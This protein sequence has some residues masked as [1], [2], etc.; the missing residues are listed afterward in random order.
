V[1]LQQAE[2]RMVRWLCG[3][4]LQDKVQSKGLRDRLG[5][6]DIISVLPQ[7]RLRWYRHVLQK[8]DNDWVK[9]IRMYEVVGARPI[10]RP[11]KTWREIVEK[12]CQAHKLNT[13]IAMDRNRW[14]K[15]M[16]DG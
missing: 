1:A 6:N 4:K 2:M 3:I 11:K 7:D 13:E 8:E 12:G 10:G 15:Q 9:K 14:R 5:L 16:R